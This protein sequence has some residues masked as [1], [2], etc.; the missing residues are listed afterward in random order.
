MHVFNGQ[1]KYLSMSHNYGM[2]IG[3]LINTVLVPV[4][5]LVHAVYKGLVIKWVFLNECR[6][7]YITNT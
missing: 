1:C 2:A 6:N 7:Q 5:K 4:H 3:H